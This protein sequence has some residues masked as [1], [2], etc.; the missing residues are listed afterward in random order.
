MNTIG[1]T[2]IRVTFIVTLIVFVTATSARLHADTGTCGGGPITLPF[3]DCEQA[4]A[5]L[6]ELRS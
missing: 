1:R 5:I 2:L 3:T 4:G 6:R